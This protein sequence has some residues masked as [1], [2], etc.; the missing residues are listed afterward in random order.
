MI[1]V[2]PYTHKQLAAMYKVSWLTLQKWLKPHFDEIGH[3]QGHFYTSRQIEIIFSK[4][5]RPEMD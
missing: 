1:T 2:R 3:K 4:I 5:G